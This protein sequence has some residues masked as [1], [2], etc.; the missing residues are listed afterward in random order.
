MTDVAREN[1]PSAAYLEHRRNVRLGVALWLACCIASVA[2]RGVRW[3]E[4]YEHAQVITRQVVYPEGHPLFR[5][6]R[7][8]FSTQTY[9]SAAALWLGAGPTVLCGL[10]NVLFLAATVLPVFLLTALLTRRA[11]WAHMAALLALEGVYLAFEGSYPIAAWPNLF[12]NGHIGGGY[13]LLTLWALVSGH[14]RLGSVLLGLMPCVHIGQMP[15]LLG[16]AP[17]YALCAWRGPRRKELV[18]ALG[19]LVA[20]L[21]GCAVFYGV[22]RHFAVDPPTQGPYCAQGDTWGI[23]HGYTA[24]HD[25]HRMFPP[26]NGHVVLVG[27]L[28]LLL[29]AAYGETRR[30]SGTMWRWLLVYVSGTAACVWGVMAVHRLMGADVPFVLISWMPYRLIN[31]VPPLLLAALVGVLAGREN[32]E[33]EDRLG[34]VG[35]L[36]VTALLAYGALRPVLG[37]LFSDDFSSRYIL[38]GD[39]AFF[40]LFGAAIVTLLLRLKDDH[41]PRAAIAAGVA[42]LVAVAILATYHQFG[43]ACVVAG[44][45]GA[46]ALSRVRRK[47]W[48]LNALVPGA[49]CLAVVSALLSHEWRGR[50][51]LPVSVFDRRVTQC[52]RDRGETQAMLVAEPGEFILQARTGHPVLVETATASLISYMPALAPIIQQIYADVYGIRFDQAPARRPETTWQDRWTTRSR[53][54]WQALG[55]KYGF[56]YIV[57]PSSMTLDLPVV[58]EAQAVLLYQV[59]LSE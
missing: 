36:V 7:G 8:A 35:Q 59:P 28:L 43:A 10:R 21:A 2:V 52:L 11:L 32:E 22:Q 4:T 48:L 34:R 31:H 42:S 33:E 37:S 30:Q 49:L 38:P 16:L 6:T 29:L 39:A 5:Y 19:W 54:E 25:T 41:A 1:R 14:W 24:Y 50:E 15:V 56:R 44:G 17:L 23:W 3:D 46:C 27:A 26:G 58:L 53:A 45:V 51:Q 20:G 18:R 57:A 12:S 55:R 40:L 47:P 9:G 13:A